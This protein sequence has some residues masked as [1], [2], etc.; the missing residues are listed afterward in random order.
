MKPTLFA[1]R[2]LAT[3]LLLAASA[4]M[5]GACDWLRGTK[6]PD[7][8]TLLIS[9]SDVSQARLVSSFLFRQL[10]DPECDQCEP[11]IQLLA[12]DTTMV[13]LPYEKTFPFTSTLQV[14]LEVSPEVVSTLAMEVLIDDR[15]WFNDF[16]TVD[17]NADPVPEVLRFIYEY[18]DI[19]F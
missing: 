15:E 3:M 16:R 14:F 7:T 11:I 12:A 13:Q 1:G 4:T 19:S 2:R 17:P 10:P 5:L 18:E 8:V 9:S 6:E